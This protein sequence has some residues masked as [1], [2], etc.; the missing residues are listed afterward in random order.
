MSW[1]AT[2]LGNTAFATLCFYICVMAALAIK[3]VGEGIH[4]RLTTRGAKRNAKQEPTA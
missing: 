3:R 4:G 1:L 2:E